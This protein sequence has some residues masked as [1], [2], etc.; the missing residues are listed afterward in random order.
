MNELRFLEVIGKID[1]DLLKEAD[2][3][4]EKQYSSKPSIAKR[5]IYAFGSVA[6][7]AV[8]TVG[9]VAVYTSHPPSD[10]LVDHSIVHQDI[11][12]KN[13]NETNNKG[14]SSATDYDDPTEKSTL[15]EDNIQQTDPM[16]PQ[17]TSVSD[18]SF[19]QTTTINNS[20]EPSTPSDNKTPQITEPQIN[21]YKGGVS[22]ENCYVQP[23]IATIDSDFDDYGVDELH[24]IDVRTADGSYRQLRPEEYDVNGISSEIG[25]SDFGG[26]IGKIV[27]VND[28]DYHGNQAESQE[29]AI[30]GADV[31]YYAPMGNNKVF[32]IVKKGDQ[33][34]MFIDDNVNVSSGFQNGL[35]F[36]DVNS[37]DDIQTIEYHIDVPD[38]SGRMITAVQKTITDTHKINSFYEL[39]CQLQ[40]E[41]YSDLPEHIGTP[42]WLVDAWANYDAASD[43]PAREDYCIAIKLKDGTVLQDINYRP[44][45]GNGY[46]EGMQE[47]TAEQNTELRTLLG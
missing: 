8:V 31:Y 42:Q 29:P 15:N 18:D 19:V 30:A 39:I 9:S 43:A 46:I 36:F 27:E 33:C 26:Y 25:N 10:L 23:F 7:A 6:A 24:H 4:I 45:L 3:D 20:N 14:I 22:A 16:N 1:E 47:L 11:S 13:N 32:I 34:S 41:D 17:A 5:R 21:G 44:Y 12:S 38:N 40:P 37:A 28:H 35:A 2:V